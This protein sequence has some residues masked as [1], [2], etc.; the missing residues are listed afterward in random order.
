MENIKDGVMAD[1]ATKNLY[2]SNTIAGRLA[3]V[4]KKAGVPDRKIR[5][6][7]ADICECTPQAVH[8]WY[9]GNTST[10]LADN[11]AAIAKYFSADLMWIITGEDNDVTQAISKNAQGIKITMNDVVIDISFQ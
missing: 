10:P 3:L 2:N 7:F 8:H 5:S 1:I 9:D 11:I 6:T 4:A